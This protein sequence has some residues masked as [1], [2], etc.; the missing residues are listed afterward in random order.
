MDIDLFFAGSISDAYKE[1]LQTFMDDLIAQGLT[2]NRPPRIRFP[3]MNLVTFKQMTM[4]RRDY[5]ARL[6]FALR[7]P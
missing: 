5:D 1:K 3:G 2:E 4:L 6:T 7:R